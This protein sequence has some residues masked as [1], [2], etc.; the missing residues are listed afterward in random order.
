VA[1]VTAVAALRHI[2]PKSY[3]PH[4]LHRGERAWAESNC[5]IDVWIEVLH[6]LGCEPL[7]CLAFVLGVDWEGDQFTFFKPPLEDLVELY[8]VDVQEL[9]V[10]KSTLRNAEQ[11][12]R[13][14][15]IVLSEIDSFYLPDTVGTDYRLQH[16]KTTIGIQEVDVDARTLGYFHN[17]SYHVLRDTDFVGLFRLDAPV[18]PTYM[19]FFAELVRTHR[20]VRLEERMLVARSVALLRK[21]VAR[22]PDDNPIARFAKAFVLDVERL[23]TEGLAAYHAYA[24]ATI[25]QLGAACELAAVYLRWL[26]SQGEVALEPSALAFDAISMTSKS[27]ILK[28]ARAVGTNKAVDLEPMLREVESQWAI[29][30]THLA[31]RYGV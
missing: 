3:I 20:V 27:L 14:G 26:E 24:F 31:K 30:M 12:L 9:T 23:K 13:G 8:G 22:R 2:N 7:A 4:D 21:H 10:Y 1:L 29:G 18:D 25:R 19:P 15:N 6:T 28:T 11:Q 17:S 5:Y 16:V